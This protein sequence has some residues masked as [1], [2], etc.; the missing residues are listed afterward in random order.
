MLNKKQRALIDLEGVIDDGISL[1]SHSLQL[2][3]L[4]MALEE[5]ARGTAHYYE[6]LRL[7]SL[8][9]PEEYKEEF[10]KLK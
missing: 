7:L 6:A 1:G 9:L 4:G 2:K 5:S 8:I 3:V 10:E